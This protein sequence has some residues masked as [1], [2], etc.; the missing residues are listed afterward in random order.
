MGMGSVT[1]SE[2]PTSGLTSCGMATASRLSPASAART[3]TWLGSRLGLGLGLGSGLG[4]G[5]RAPAASYPCRVVRRATRRVAPHLV[6]A[7][8][9]WMAIGGDV[10]IGSVGQAAERKP[11]SPPLGRGVAAVMRVRP[12]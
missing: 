8:R 12:L 11:E 1:R 10:T 2:A 5:G 4:L 7:S 9:T 6:R 3:R